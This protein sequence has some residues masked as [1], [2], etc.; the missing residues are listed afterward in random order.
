MK[1][2]FK[3]SVIRAI[4]IFCIP[5][6]TLLCFQFLCIISGTS[7]FGIPEHFLSF[8]RTVAVVALTT[9]ALSINLSSGRFDFSLGAVALLSSLVAAQLSLYFHLPVI[10]MLLFSAVTGIL[11]G[12]IS[13]GLYV[14]LH[15]PPIII[16]L[17]T[18]LMFE[19]ISYILTKGRGVSLATKVSYVQFANNIWYI[20]LI[21]VLA[22]A[23]I[24]FL[25][26]YTKFGYEHRALQTGQK[27]AVETGINEKKNAIISYGI[28]GLFMG[29]VGFLNALT[30]GTIQ[31]SLNFSSLAAMFVAFLPMF[32]GG[33]I[34]RWI[35]EQFGMLLGAITS[36]I[37]T[38]GFVR[39]N[40]ST[41][42]QSLVN[43]FI[44]LL[45]LLYLNNE[46][47]FAKLLFKRGSK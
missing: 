10:C 27:I 42:V 24:W 25:T 28:A 2:S 34:G 6:G 22:T 17:G 9:Y 23:L 13:G 39:L 40:L 1:S 41:Q 5:L 35:N 37:I 8:V 20:L 36:A 29:V 32:I 45:F 38:L 12:V 4:K 43:S 3:K 26:Q 30:Q 15:I 19:S 46:Q 18:T 16:S 21:I 14:L 11:L 7:L 33:F 31:I 47:F 44:L